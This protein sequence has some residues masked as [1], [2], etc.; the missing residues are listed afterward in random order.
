MRASLVSGNTTRSIRID[1][2]MPDQ[3]VT[4]IRTAH[5]LT[6]DRQRIADACTERQHREAIQSNTG[7]KQAGIN[8]QRIDIVVNACRQSGSLVNHSGKLHGLRPVHERC[9]RHYGI[10]DDIPAQRDSHGAR[11]RP[12]CHLRLVGTVDRQLFDQRDHGLRRRVFDFQIVASGDNLP[13]CVDRNRRN[14][15]R[16]DFHADERSR[17]LDYS[18]SHLRAAATF[19][20]FFLN[21]TFR[22]F[23]GLAG[24]HRRLLDHASINQIA[25]NTG[26]RALRKS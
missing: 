2:N 16:I 22:Q 4:F 18:Q 10:V 3:T 7:P 25:G 8:D 19:R 21:E 12:S 26:N 13:D 6:V 5:Q 1:Q 14:M 20:I 23:T 24:R 11:F 9:E 15:R 17:V